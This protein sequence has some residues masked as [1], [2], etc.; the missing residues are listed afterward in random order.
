MVWIK[1]TSLHLKRHH[2]KCIMN[3]K[4]RMPSLKERERE[5]LDTATTTSFHFLSH[6][7]GHV[8][9]MVRQPGGQHIAA[10]PGCR[11]SHPRGNIACNRDS[12]LCHSPP[13]RIQTRMFQQGSCCC[14]RGKRASCHSTGCCTRTR[15][16][17]WKVR[18]VTKEWSPS[19]GCP[20]NSVASTP[21][22]LPIVREWSRSIHCWTITIQSAPSTFP[23]ATEWS[24]SE[25]YRTNTMLTGPSEHPNVTELSPPRRCC[26]RTN[27]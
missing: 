12:S 21:L 10:G 14:C 17:G 18:P 27:K 5:R 3:A 23:A 1:L 2:F 9:F 16:S 19:I 20:V 7:N 22:K 11:P 15:P 4:K 24:P 26:P 13:P 25:Y 8:L 6:N